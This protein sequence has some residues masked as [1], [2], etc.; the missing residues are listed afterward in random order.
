MQQL[1]VKHLCVLQVWNV[2]FAA[3]KKSE[4]ER[5]TVKE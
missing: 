1:L 2:I 4:K 5:K 3:G